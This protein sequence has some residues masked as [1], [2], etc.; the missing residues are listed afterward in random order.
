MENTRVEA[1]KQIPRA[2]PRVPLV[3]I[4]HASSP[5]VERRLHPLPPPTHRK[6]RKLED[7]RAEAYKKSPRARSPLVCMP[8]A[9]PPR[10]ERHLH[11][12]PP[13]HSGRNANGKVQAPKHTTTKIARPPSRPACMHSTSTAAKSTGTLEP[14]ASGFGG[15]AAH[16]PPH[17]QHAATPPAQYLPFLYSPG[18][19]QCTRHH[20]LARYG[21]LCYSR[22]AS[23]RHSLTS[24]RPARTNRLYCGRRAVRCIR[25]LSVRPS[26]CFRLCCVHGVARRLW[27][28]SRRIPRNVCLCCGCGSYRCL[29]VSSC[30]PLRSFWRCNIRCN[31]NSHTC[32]CDGLLTRP[33]FL[34]LTTL[35]C[36]LLFVFP[37]H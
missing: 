31:D 18:S 4:P 33:G 11:P 30:R 16:P 15:V 12:L 17:D 8:Q 7:T 10:V 22:R 29:H 20:H 2:H 25:L 24:I 27:L 19:R 3:C 35:F 34:H 37:C 26:R 9:L 21:F 14:S 6:K 1:Q 13:T 36:N 5:K 23:R 28:F 32:R